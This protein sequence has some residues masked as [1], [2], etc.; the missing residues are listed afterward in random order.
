M[1]AECKMIPP[2]NVFK[3]RD[4][5]GFLLQDPQSYS[6][7]WFSFLNIALF[8]LEAV[9]QSSTLNWRD[10]KSRLWNL[11]VRRAED[12]LAQRQISNYGSTFSNCNVFFCLS[13]SNQNYWINLKQGQDFKYEENRLNLRHYMYSTRCS[14]NKFSESCLRAMI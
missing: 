9:P 2:V 3:H 14:S 11:K 10:R 8:T 1:F 5:H 6:V 7:L 13:A 12:T 4:E